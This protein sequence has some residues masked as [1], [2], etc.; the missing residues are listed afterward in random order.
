MIEGFNNRFKLFLDSGL[1]VGLG[2]CLDAQC[3]SGVVN[4]LKAGIRLRQ[5]KTAHA[6]TRVL[7]IWTLLASVGITL[8]VS[9]SRKNAV[10]FRR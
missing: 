6:K 7:R 5:Y 3:S 8:A 10:D 2:S 1:P 4:E 9:S